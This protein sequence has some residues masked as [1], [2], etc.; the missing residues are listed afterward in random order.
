[1]PLTAAYWNAPYFWP[2]RDALALTDHL[3]GLS[4]ITTPLQWC[5]GSVPR[6]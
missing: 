4:P 2:M 5:N 6:R 3:A 1:V